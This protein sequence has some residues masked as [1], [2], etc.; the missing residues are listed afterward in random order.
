MRICPNCGRENGDNRDFCEC[1]EYL[2]WEPTQHL[3]AFGASAPGAAAAE[4]RER[5]HE[6]AGEGAGG[7]ADP[8][9]TLAPGAPAVSG[10]SAL[11]ASDV[12]AAAPVVGPGSVQGGPPAGAARLL[13]RLPDA[14]EQPGGPV[15]AG[16][17]P[18]ERLMV[19]ALVRNESGIVDNYDIGVRGLPAGWWTVTPAT[20]YL[21]PYG[22]GGN[23]EQEVQVHVHP[24][25]TPEAQARPWAYEVTAFSRAFGV[26]VAAAAASVRI[27]PYQDVVGKVAPDRAAGRLK[28]RFLLTLRN[29]ANAPVEV[30]LEAVD[31]EGECE[32]RFAQ[33]SV[34]IDPGRGI[35]APFTVFPA[36]QL[37]I[38]RPQDRPIRVTATPVG[39]PAPPAAMPATYRQRAWLP[40][41]LSIAVPLVAVIAAAVILLTPKQTVVPNLKQAKNVFAAQT[42][43]TAAGLNSQVE[44]M[45][46]PNAAPGSI[47]GQDPPPGTKVKRG[48]TVRILEAL[49]SG[50]VNVPNVVGMRADAADAVLLRLG[51]QLQGVP[52]LEPSATIVSQLPRGNT[53]VRA[54]SPIAVFFAAPRSGNAT[55]NTSS[56]ASAG[57]PITLP[58]V[59]GEGAVAVV[60]KLAQLGVAST[61]V[62]RFDT[63]AQGTV[64]G[65]KPP[66]ASGIPSGKTVTLIVSA[67]LPELAYD[68]GSS[69][70]VVDAATKKAAGNNPPRTTVA[71]EASWSSD[72]RDLVYVQSPQSTGRLMLFAP[73]QSG[74]RPV[75]LTAPGSD[76]RDPEFAPNNRALAFIDRSRGFGRLCFAAV[77]PDT[78][79][80]VTAPVSTDDCTRHR[81]FDL[82]RQISWS[83]GGGDILVY[84]SPI[85]SHGTEHALVEFHTNV[86]FATNAAAWDHGTVVTELTQD[87]IA[88]AFSPDRRYVA[89][90]SDFGTPNTFYL[91]LAPPTGFNL[92]NARKITAVLACQVS[93]RS[94]SQALAVMQSGS[95]CFPDAS[96]ADPRGDI[97]TFDLSSPDAEETIASNSEHPAWQPVSLGG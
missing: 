66:L 41:W 84:G 87:V 45:T 36:K 50:K 33:P 51:L 88:G 8:E 61:I 2:R 3:Q 18:G 94:D 26:E 47:I 71:G 11:G 13:L 67:G 5:V 70:H 86:P 76:E 80:Q 73:N 82:G 19:L 58:A 24:P 27:E 1:G 89:L 83:P 60:E 96:G 52:Q 12:A 40:W 22:T 44:S 97:K 77:N 69:I 53:S 74:A 25:R 32:F 6:G 59:T 4:P 93:W 21:V 91:Y 35:E 14:E 54:G 90:L 95:G 37:W 75:P 56:T 29:R 10:P 49:G 55:G 39:A 81:G 92:A 85:A 63:S 7:A 72:G 79:N 43:L 38:G 34:V 31:A 9:L 48:A 46:E 57:K 16:V 78:V 20:A 28:A 30:R 65:T 15:S 68:N 62:Q 42:Q 64:I 23:Y 17:R